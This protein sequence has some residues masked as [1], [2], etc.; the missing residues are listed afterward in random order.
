MKNAFNLEPIKVKIDNLIETV[1]N[2]IAYRKI[3]YLSIL[4]S[5]REVGILQPITVCK[6]N[7]PDKYK[8]LDGHL[9]VNALRELGI[10]ET[11]CLL[12]TDDERYTFDAQ[13]N[14]LNPF[15]RA[16][17]IEKAISNG[18]SAERIAKVLGIDTADVMSDVRIT[19]GIDNEAKEILKTSPIKK[20]ALNL[21]RKVKSVRQIEIAK[22]MVMMNKYSFLYA[23]GLVLSTP[24]S[25][26]I[27]P[28]STV[29]TKY[30]SDEAL[31]SLSAERKN[32]DLRIKE[33]EYRYNNNVYE[34]TTVTAFLRR[35]LKN[36]MLNNY[37]EKHFSECYLTLQK[38]AKMNEIDD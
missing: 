19:N 38:I 8:I 18:L 1:P 3:A 23:Q 37:L 20:S 30:F 16:R 35:I 4:A 26:L 13:I 9:R 32:M 17:M 15:Q 28:K 10:T 11:F 36:E 27:K 21:L 33:A 6:S 22:C 24:A 29:I 25:M 5:V 34:L 2:T 14:N 12:S 7:E 31:V